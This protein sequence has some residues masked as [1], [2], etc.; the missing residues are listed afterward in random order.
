[1]YT[2]KFPT[3]GI[4]DTS[5]VL[6]KAYIFYQIPANEK[7]NYSKIFYY[8]LVFNFLLRNKLMEKLSF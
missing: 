2:L 5:T 7:D 3:I 4:I 6:Q 1:M 8:K